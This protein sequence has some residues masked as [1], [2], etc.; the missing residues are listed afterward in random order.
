MLVNVTVTALPQVSGSLL[1]VGQNWTELIRQRVPDALVVA[2][3]PAFSVVVGNDGMAAG[4]TEWSLTC[5][6]SFH[7]EVQLTV[8]LDFENNQLSV[9]GEIPDAILQV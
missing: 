8:L 9:K 1:G 3:L 2:G 4:R 6:L 5:S 7:P